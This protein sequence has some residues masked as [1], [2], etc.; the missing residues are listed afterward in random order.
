[1]LKALNDALPM[2][3]YGDMFFTAWYGVYHTGATTLTFAAAGHPPALWFYDRGERRIE[4]SAHDVPIGIMPGLE[5]Q[6][7]PLSLCPGSRIYLYSDGVYE[8]TTRNGALWS[9]EE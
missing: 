7:T 2:D 5:F 6:E 1:M 9:W 8:F 4:F 3:R